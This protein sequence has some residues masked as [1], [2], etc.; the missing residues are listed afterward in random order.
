MNT[1]IGLAVGLVVGFLVGY[2]L[3]GSRAPEVTVAAPIG[4]A[5]GGAP[6]PGGGIPPGAMP[7]AQPSMQQRLAIGE[8]LVAKEPKNPQAWIELGNDY[9]DTHQQQKAID[10]YAKALALAPNNPDV[11][12]DQGVMYRELGQ[13]DKAVAN[14]R[15]ANELNPKHTQSL[16]NL[17]VVYAKDLNQ[18]DKAIDAWN[19][20]VAIAPTS[21]QAIQARQAIDEYRKAR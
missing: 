17:G 14:F 12:T 15:K 2:Q 18:V 7:G 16:Y 6:M 3:G 20:V 13:F 21:P 11:L 19:R 9:F 1:L 8:Q 4:P 10:A 5:G